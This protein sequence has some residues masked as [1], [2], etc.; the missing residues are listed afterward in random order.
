MHVENQRFS[1]AVAPQ[2][3]IDIKNDLKLQPNDFSGKIVAIMG[4]PSSGKSNTS[5]RLA[6]Q[7]LNYIQ[8]G[9]IIDADG[10]H[11]GLKEHYP[12]IRVAG[13]E[14]ADE[15]LVNPVR[16]AERS[17][18]DNLVFV[19]DFSGMRKA[20][21][22]EFLEQY[23]DH[24]F[25]LMSPES[26]R[27][28]YLLMVE[29]AH[30]FMPQD[31]TTPVFEIFSNFA[32]RGRK[33]GVVTIYTTQFPRY[34]N[35]KVLRPVEIYFFHRVDHPL[36][37]DIYAEYIPRKKERVH[38]LA[39]LL[40]APGDCIFRQGS[41]VQVVKIL[42]RATRHGGHTPQIVP[43]E[44]GENPGSY[45]RNN[46]SSEG[47][48]AEVIAPAIAMQPDV[49]GRWDAGYAAG[50]ARLLVD[51]LR[52]LCAKIE[53]GG[54]LRRKQATVKDVEIVALP[55]QAA[56]LLARLDMWVATGKIR[57]AMY[58]DAGRQ[59]PRWGDKYRGFVYAGIRFE[60]F[61]ADADNWGFILWLRT[62]PGDANQ[63]VMTQLIRLGAPYRPALGYLRE[64]DD[65]GEA[66]GAV[67]RVAGEAE[68]FRL[69][70]MDYLAPEDRTLAAYEAALK[71]PHWWTQEWETVAVEAA[72][73]QTGMFE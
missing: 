53:L 54:S 32:L 61:L 3:R 52:D 50:H 59:T 69:L 48:I 70:A 42:L 62:G 23:L 30:L 57:K 49:N 20:A 16:L 63:Y 1:Q 65:R 72:P 27:K 18:R 31:G 68:M 13:G 19:L 11:W 58:G 43:P 28:P 6:E 26:A 60:I 38:E 51:E 39:A 12:Q 5:A 7:L 29:E 34:I 40:Q 15:P 71:A 9:T 24:L 47:A 37:I 8:C 46:V 25:D 21:M 17:F 2:L 41:R 22:F 4:I 14:H 66:T 33:R 45:D 67:I 10:D 64:C 35:K 55:H 56:A 44:A 73:T 36:D